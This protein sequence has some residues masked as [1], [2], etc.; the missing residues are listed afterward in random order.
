[1]AER[2]TQR[3]APDGQQQSWVKRF[4]AERRAEELDD[5]RLADAIRD[6]VRALLAQHGRF[7]P[8]LVP[9]YLDL[10]IDR[11]DVRD[12]LHASNALEAILTEW[13]AERGE[14]LGFTSAIDVGIAVVG[15]WNERVQS[16]GLVQAGA[17]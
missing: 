14:R 10:V 3:E 6:D 8:T 17:Q 12:G 4:H 11:A 5:M 9:A 15:G 13:L 7:L 1:M 16:A 2:R